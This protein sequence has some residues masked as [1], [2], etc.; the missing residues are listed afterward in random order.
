MSLIRRD[1][2]RKNDMSTK[3]SNLGSLKRK[4]KRSLIEDY[5]AVAMF[6]PVYKRMLFRLYFYDGYSTIEISQLM[7]IQAATVRRRLMGICEELN[8]MVERKNEQI[9][10]HHR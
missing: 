8:E 6:L 4:E 1:H 7:M 3:L 2:R 9:Q 10:R 5:C